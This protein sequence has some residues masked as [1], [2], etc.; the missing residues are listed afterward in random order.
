MHILL[1]AGTL[2]RHDS[3][4]YLGDAGV[5]SASFESSVDVDLKRLKIPES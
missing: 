4:D 2:Y 5:A 1:V 3:S